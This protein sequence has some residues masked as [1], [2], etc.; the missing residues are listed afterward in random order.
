MDQASGAAGICI[1][2]P[3]QSTWAEA[4]AAVVDEDGGPDRARNDSL[5][6]SWPSSSGENRAR[7]FLTASDM[8]GPA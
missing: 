1:T 2:L 5:P 3:H 4:T 6:I 7:H 8:I